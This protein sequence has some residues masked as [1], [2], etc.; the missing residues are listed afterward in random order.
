MKRSTHLEA[1][2]ILIGRNAETLE[3]C[4]P[5]A[6]GAAKLMTPLE[7]ERIRPFIPTEDLG[8]SK[9]FYEALGFKKVLDSE[10]VIFHNY[11]GGF[12]LAPVTESG[13]LNGFMMQIMV[14]GRPSR[15]RSDAGSA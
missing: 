11:A 2:P 4:Q 8:I 6:C 15:F 1:L 14:D 3:K 9:R 12:I 10:V 7:S 13:L 5:H